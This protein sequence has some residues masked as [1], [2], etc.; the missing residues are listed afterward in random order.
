MTLTLPATMRTIFD[1]ID[2][3]R[4]PIANCEVAHQISGLQQVDGLSDAQ[5]RGAWAEALASNF[6][7]SDEISRGTRCGPIFKATKAGGTPFYAPDIA[8]ID[9]E[10]TTHWEQHSGACSFQ[11]PR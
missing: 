2:A 11:K 6:R 9:K 3:A 10:I 5:R 1:A 7:P 8:G 4:Q